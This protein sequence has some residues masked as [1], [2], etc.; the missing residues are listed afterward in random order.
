MCLLNKKEQ[1]KYEKAVSQAEEELDIVKY[2]RLQK[3]IRSLHRHLFTDLERYLLRN[4]QCFVINS[5]KDD[6]DSSIDDCT[7]FNT[8]QLENAAN[9]AYFGRFLLGAFQ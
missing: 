2:I 3:M 9:S 7:Y 8:E 4:Q 5:K 1:L 6:S